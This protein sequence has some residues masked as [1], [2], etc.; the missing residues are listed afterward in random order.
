MYWFDEK[1]LPK[2]S[3]NTLKKKFDSNNISKEFD[4]FIIVSKVFQ[5]MN[6]NDKI[7]YYF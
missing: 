3:Y 2:V 6:I 5:E 1:L 4:K 7:T